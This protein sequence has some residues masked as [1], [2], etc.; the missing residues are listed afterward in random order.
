M[1]VPVSIPMKE[2]DEDKSVV[3]SEVSQK[4]SRYAQTPNINTPP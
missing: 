1:D 2:E 3:S 4:T